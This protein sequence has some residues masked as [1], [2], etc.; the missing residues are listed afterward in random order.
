MQPAWKNRN[1]NEQYCLHIKTEKLS[2]LYLPLQNIVPLMFITSNFMAVF[3]FEY[4]LMGVVKPKFTRRNM[5]Q[6]FGNRRYVQKCAQNAGSNVLMSTYQLFM[7][8]C[9]KK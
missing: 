4:S 5:M 1:S 7:S 2:T 6:N 9:Q 3:C 8:T